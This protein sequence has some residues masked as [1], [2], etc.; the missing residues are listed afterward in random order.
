MPNR[1]AKSYIDSLLAFWPGL[2]VMKGDLKGAIKMH[3]TLNQIVKKYDFLPEAVL[4][5][6][7]VH[8]GGHPLRPEFLEST[9]YLYKA[10]HDEYYLEIAK[11]A[12]LQL[13]KYSRVK[14]GYAAI[15]D[16][17]TKTKEDRMDSFVF[18]ETF[19]YL[20]LI[21]EEEEALLFDLN[22]FLF[23]TEAH[24]LPLKIE[25]YIGN[26][27]MKK[28]NQIGNKSWMKKSCPSLKHLFNLK[29]ATELERAAVKEAAKKVRDSVATASNFEHTCQQMNAFD[30]NNEAIRKMPL[31]AAE[32]VAGRKDH[33]DILGQIG[34]KLIT[35][36]DGRVQLMHKTEYARSLEDAETGILFMTEMLELS[37]QQDF[38]LK[39]NI[40]VDEN[41]PMSL[42]LLNPPINGTKQF[43]A[44]SAQF[45]YDLR[46]Y[47]GIFG[48]LQLAEPLDA[49]MTLSAN[50]NY[51]D[52]IVVAKRGNCM[53]IEKARLVESSGNLNNLLISLITAFN[54]I[55]ACL[56]SA[57]P[58][59]Y[60][61]SR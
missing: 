41:R 15:T 53:F 52:K 44:G 60:R 3:E 29:D 54:H 42:I 25:Q 2:Q 50:V 59:R 10:T 28:A 12:L 1:Q 56:R 39:S 21:F 49:C 48:K 23:T 47:V 57:R 16:V 11:K 22:E 40:L 36:Q 7:T 43:H 33:M 26:A 24:L 31:R 38:Q 14:C 55:N 61:Q 34:I 13:E 46:K 4:F 45:G 32:F 58:D 5:D 6:Y 51:A 30:A 19:K 37:K 35:M 8:W 18:A 27:E 17:K 9:Y 20:Y